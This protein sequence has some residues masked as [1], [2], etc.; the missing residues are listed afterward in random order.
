M[1][2]Q[3]KTPKGIKIIAGLMFVIGL[4]IFVHSGCGLL[5]MISIPDP[6]EFKII[7]KGLGLPDVI[8]IGPLF[9]IA[10]IGLWNMKMWGIFVCLLAFGG[11]ISTDVSWII[12]YAWFAKTGAITYDIIWDML[13]LG[14]LIFAIISIV[15]LW[16]KRKC[17][18]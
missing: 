5:G 11:R 15:Y 1:D 6:V 10:S 12:P 18:S 9:I 7:T 8:F 2:E 13:G 17:F 16:R 3:I 14:L 4:I